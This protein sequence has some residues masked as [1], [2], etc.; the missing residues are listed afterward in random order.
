MYT[1]YYPVTVGLQMPAPVPQE[2]WYV[3]FLREFLSYFIFGFSDNFFMVFFAD[4]IDPIVSSWLSKKKMSQRR[5]AH[6]AAGYGNLGS[7]VMG[8]TLGDTLGNS[9]S[10]LVFG[11]RTGI[12]NEKFT[13]ISRII[14]IAFG[15]WVGMYAGLVVAKNKEKGL[16]SSAK[17]RLSYVYQ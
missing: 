1:P 7:D 11:G 6:L 12:P 17:A 14:G 15:C 9:V 10:D 3:T 5:L 8:L 13:L 16:E 4:T 2:I